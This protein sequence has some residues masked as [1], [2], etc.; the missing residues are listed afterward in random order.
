LLSCDAL[1]VPDA[2]QHISV[3]SV[4]YQL[5]V[6][7]PRDELKVSLINPI[8]YCT[9]SSPEELFD[10]ALVSGKVLYFGIDWP[11]LVSMCSPVIQV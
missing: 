7:T 9:L 5:F 3:D 10:S 4:Q 2:E 8:D 1:L 11:T 6:R